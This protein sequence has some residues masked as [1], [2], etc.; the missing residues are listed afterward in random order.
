MGYPSEIP[1]SMPGDRR[2][3]IED[4]FSRFVRWSWAYVTR[5]F[6]RRKTTFA[7][8]PE[9]YHR[10]IDPTRPPLRPEDVAQL[11]VEALKRLTGP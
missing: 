10:G 11:D 6:R 1:N 2:V 4:P 9:R 8:H 3:P 7:Q 5:P